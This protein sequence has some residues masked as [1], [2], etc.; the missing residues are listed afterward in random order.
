[1]GRWCAV[2]T[3]RASCADDEAAR[4]N[5][6]TF[7]VPTEW[8]GHGVGTPSGWG[9][10]GCRDRPYR[11]V[12]TTAPVTEAAPAGPRTSRA[13]REWLRAIVA[14]AGLLSLFFIAP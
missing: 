13:K 5:R 11:D 1:M 12:V 8:R 2:E 7:L 4:R 10:C 3:P 14:M 9:E 6:R